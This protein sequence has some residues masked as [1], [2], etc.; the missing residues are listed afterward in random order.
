MS[1]VVILTVHKQ[2]RSV[3]SLLV[4]VSPVSLVTG[5]KLVIRTAVLTVQDRDVVCQMESVLV[6]WLVDGDL[7][8]T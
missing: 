4:S 5:E 7:N 3:T 2:D 6:V 1:R 8:V